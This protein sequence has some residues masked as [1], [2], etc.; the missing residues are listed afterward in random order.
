MNKTELAIL[1][2]LADLDEATQQQVL[3]Y[4]T[5]LTTSRETVPL[6][7]GEWMAEAEAF[8]TQL[9]QKYGEGHFNTQALLDE[10]REEESE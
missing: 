8:R 10:L 9:R 5:H 3:G 2:K 6:S 1:Q 4:L 7:L